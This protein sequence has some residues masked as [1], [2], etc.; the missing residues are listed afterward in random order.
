MSVGQVAGAGIIFA[1][2]LVIS[3]VIVAFG[4]KI[5]CWNEA[6]HPRV[7]CAMLTI[8]RFMAVWVRPFRPGVPNPIGSSLLHTSPC[9]KYGLCC[10]P[11]FLCVLTCPLIG[12]CPE[13]QEFLV[14]LHLPVLLCTQTWAS[15]YAKLGPFSPSNTFVDIILGVDHSS[16]SRVDGMQSYSWC[17]GSRG[18]HLFPLVKTLTGC[19]AP[20]LCAQKKCACR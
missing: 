20:L 3:I 7:T 15:G 14:S 1:L 8:A 10:P 17:G 16:N 4:E 9:S 18:P 13:C 5:P 6:M 19:A 11:G 2:I 12:W